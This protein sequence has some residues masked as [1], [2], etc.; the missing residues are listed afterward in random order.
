MNKI[1]RPKK[2]RETA[3][4][5]DELESKLL[6]FGECIM[7]G[8]GIFTLREIKPREY[9][10]RWSKN[11]IKSKGYTKIKFKPLPGFFERMQSKQ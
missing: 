8:Q 4:S 7:A 3:Y 2:N 5:Q 6:E 11:R 9:T 10:D 1:G